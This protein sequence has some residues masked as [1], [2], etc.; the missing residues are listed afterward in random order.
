[1]LRPTR[2]PLALLVGG[3]LLLA[4]CTDTSGSGPPTDQRPGDPP[5]RTDLSFALASFDDCG[6]FESRVQSVAA[7][8]IGPWGFDGGGDDMAFTAVGRAVEDQAGAADAPERLASPSTTTLANTDAA[9]ESSAREGGG[10]TGTNVQERGVDEPDLVKVDGNLVLTL[11]DG[12]LRAVRL[13]DGQPQLAGSLSMPAYGDDQL[14][15]DGNTVLVLTGAGPGIL[16]RGGGF[17]AES[18][19]MVMPSAVTLRSVD[20]SDP[21]AMSITGEVSL[22]GSMV[23]AR[24]VDGVVRVVTTTGAPDLPLVQPAGS[25]PRA[26]EAAERLN[27]EAIEATTADDW[28]PRYEVADAEG[29][30]V[31]EGPLVECSGV[32]TTRAELAADATETAETTTI[33]PSAFGMVNV[34][35][36]DL[37]SGTLAPSDAVSVMG[38]GHTLYASPTS[39]Y[40]ATTTWDQSG[41]GSESTQVHQFDTSSRETVSYVASG[42]VDG[43]LLN[44][45][46]M[47]EH[48]GDLRVATTRTT[49]APSGAEMPS[50]EGTGG[51]TSAGEI[52]NEGAPDDGGGV[53]AVAPQVAAPETTIPGP[54]DDP[55]TE[56]TEPPPPESVPGP[57]VTTTASVPTTST[58]EPAPTTTLMPDEPLPAPP[59]DMPQTDSVVT[60]LRNDGGEL[61]QVGAV[62]GLGLG[63]QIQSV[64]FMGDVGYVVTFRQIDPLY[65]IDLRDPSNPRMMGELKIPGFSSYLHP[66]GDGLLLGIGRDA[67]LT[68]R[69]TG[70]QVTVFDVADLANPS[71]L[72]RVSLPDASSE[73]EWDH[74]A[75][76]WWA[77]TSTVVVPVQEFAPTG[78]FTGAIGYRVGR[79]GIGELGRVT[80]P[81]DPTYINGSCPPG[82]DCVA[83]AVELSFGGTP[84]RRSLVVD[85]RLVTISSAGLETSSLDTLAEI[86]WLG[87]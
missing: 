14:L 17:A 35:S 84:I 40:V 2:R 72:Q 24:M 48:N 19:R 20:V 57:T 71:E 65:T 36:V 66:I 74:H 77:D 31:D 39:L 43:H 86:G 41:L 63:E 83:P 76:L 38:S 37:R 46:A 27:R 52:E 58:T 6:D 21:A 45:F 87:F 25:G 44:Q 23:D 75:F 47:S 12:E 80:H 69:T 15:A 59:V 18:S 56:T 30:L 1:M 34:V 51:T 29:D 70:M 33:G 62:G 67:D 81:E 49:F 55:P 61:R 3:L 4:A 26:Q 8:A 50:E 5:V 60:V 82:A 22:E 85:G 10:W 11:V 54:A 73:A 79:A 32:H 13:V 64:R 16:T 28:L 42:Q 78:V 68:G 7:E 9:P 53:D